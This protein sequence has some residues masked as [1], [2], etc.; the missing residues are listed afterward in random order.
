MMAVRIEALGAA[1]AGLDPGDRALLDLS[2]RQGRSD[3]DVALELGDDAAAV[4][5]RRD[6]LL[7]RLAGELG[8]RG[9]E[10][11]DELRATLPDLPRRLWPS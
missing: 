3:E 10:Q 11:H 2:L 4:A 9:R 6:G 8:L 5:R 7:A 1:L